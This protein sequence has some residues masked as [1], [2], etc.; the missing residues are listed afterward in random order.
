MSV[1]AGTVP[2]PLSTTVCGL[3][4]ASSTSE[5]PA[6]RLPAAV[7]ANV[8]EI[9]QLAPTPSVL[10]LSGQVFV[11]AKSPAFVPVTPIESIVSAALPELVRVT[12]WKRSSCP[13]AAGRSRGWSGTS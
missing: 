9:V 11:C 12:S 6:L 1:T 8:T 2:V 5:T 7:G 10:G 13:P 4:G 3:P